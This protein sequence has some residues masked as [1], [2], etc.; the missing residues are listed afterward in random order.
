MTTKITDSPVDANRQ[1]EIAKARA[2]V[3][4]RA[5]AQGIKPFRSLKDFAGDPEMTVDFDVDEFLRQVREG[6]DQSSTR[7]AE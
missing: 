6:R 3:M 5:A 1:S 4:R 7:K 2:E